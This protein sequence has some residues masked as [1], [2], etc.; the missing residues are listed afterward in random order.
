M[1][2]AA[3]CDV[4]VAPRQHDLISER[5]DRLEALVATYAAAND[6]RLTRM[7]T[8]PVDVEKIRFPPRV[9]MALV[10]GIMSVVGGMYASTYGLRSDVRN[11]LT[12]MENQKRVE[13]IQQKLSDKQAESLNKAIDAIDKRQQLQQ[14]EIQELK[15]MV[16]QARRQ[17]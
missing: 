15:E 2:A 4:D 6:I 1:S 16:L 13:E 9:V 11:I 8:N 3:A 12:T 7:D 5:L 14:I 17:P 10:L